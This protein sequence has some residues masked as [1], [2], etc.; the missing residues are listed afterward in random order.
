MVAVFV[1]DRNLRCDFVNAVAETLIGLTLSQARGRSFAD[2]LWPKRRAA[3]DA[4]ELAGVLAEGAEGEG[5]ETLVDA[6]GAARPFAFRVAQLGQTESVRHGAVVELIDLSGETGTGRALRESEQRLRLAIEAT[7]I[8]IWDVNATTGE[9]RWSP[10]FSAILGLPPDTDADPEIFASLIHPDDRAQ[11]ERL[12]REAY[13]SG[14]SGTYNAEFRIR[15]ASDHALR[16]ISTTGRI[17]FDASGR[18]LR[19]VGTLR[20]VHDL[21]TRD[22]ALRISEERHRLAVE[23]SAL[24]TWD[25]DIVTGEL[26]WSSQFKALWGL[27]ADAPSDFGLIRRLVDERS[28]ETIR[29][30]WQAAIDPSGDG[31]VRLEL[32]FTRA[33]DGERRWCAISGQVFF[34]EARRTPLRAVGIMMDTTDRREGEERQRLIMKELN[35]RVKNNLAVVQAIVSQTFRMSKPSEA[36]DRIQARLMAIARTHDFLNQSNWGG[37]SLTAL[38]KGELEPYG[39]FDGSRITL[40]GEPV[41]LDS[42]TALALGLILHELATNAAKYGSLST[43]E[44]RLMVSWRR[45]KKDEGEDLAMS[46]IEAGGPPVRAPRRTGFGSRLIDGSARGN[47]NGSVEFSYGR[48]GLRCMLQFPLPDISKLPPYELIG[49]P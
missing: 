42:K 24:G 29:R 32:P 33:D 6:R 48:Q 28:Y 14:S 3:Y 2:A 35:H 16:W 18:A 49:G 22:E 30:I 36:F 8:G 43:G 19:G 7:G 26:R 17:T 10:E 4:S 34:N 12:Y 44:G 20:D 41:T 9:R 21:R 5:V 46:W 23:A 38:L 39:A 11:V 13:A 25:Y 1:L 40:D 37:V 27:P 31:R 15:R 47:L 45:I